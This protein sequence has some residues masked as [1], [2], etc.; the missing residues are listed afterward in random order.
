MTLHATRDTAESGVVKP[1]DC[2]DGKVSVVVTD[3]HSVTVIERH[4]TNFR[5]LHKGRPIAGL[6][7]VCY[8]FNVSFNNAIVI[9]L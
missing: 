9:Y 3:E 5:Y 1:V 7:N 4:R 6:N 2:A 8:M